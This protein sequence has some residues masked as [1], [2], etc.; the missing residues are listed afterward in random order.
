MQ[1]TKFA[2]VLASAASDEGQFNQEM[3]SVQKDWHYVELP[4]NFLGLVFN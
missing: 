1:I 2:R 3:Y 4:L